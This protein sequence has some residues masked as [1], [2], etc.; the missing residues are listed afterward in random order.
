[1]SVSWIIYGTYAIL[2]MPRTTRYP[3]RA[4][5]HAQL[6]KAAI[7]GKTLTYGE[8]GGGR[9]MLG[10]YL[11]RIALEEKA[12]WRPPIT[13]LVVT[14]RH[15]RPA[16]GFRGQ[17]QEIGYVRDGESEEDVWQ[18]ALRD[19]HDYWRPKLRDELQD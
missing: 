1:M 3:Y 15:G 13:A 7:L 2:I 17:M 11:R 16:P 9:F 6:V 10:R 14:K 18:R 8:L 4:E 12:A 19:V 5:L